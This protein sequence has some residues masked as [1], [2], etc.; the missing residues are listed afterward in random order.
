MDRRCPRRLS[1]AL[2]AAVQAVKALTQRIDDTAAVYTNGTT[3][4]WNTQ[5]CSTC[6]AKPPDT[7]NVF[8]GTWHDNTVEAGADPALMTFTFTGLSFIYSRLNACE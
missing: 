8:D 6:S 1:W 4:G 5:D 7:S 2:L 3:S